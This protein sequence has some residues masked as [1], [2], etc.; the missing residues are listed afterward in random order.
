MADREPEIVVGALDA[1]QLPKQPKPVVREPEAPSPAP[2]KAVAAALVVENPQTLQPEQKRAEDAQTSAEPLD[3]AQRADTVAVAPAAPVTP[4]TAPA[5]RDAENQRPVVEP[6][7]VSTPKPDEPIPVAA[8]AVEPKKPEILVSTQ[9]SLEVTT[10]QPAPDAPTPSQPGPVIAPPVAVDAAPPPDDGTL[11]RGD[12]G[13]DVEML[14]YR[15]Q[16]VGFGGPD[17]APLQRTGHFDAPTEHAVRAFQRERGLPD[18]GHYDPDTV[19]ALA[20][21]Q[22]AK[23]ES[24]KAEKSTVETHAVEKAA[25]PT[26]MAATLNGERTVEPVA[27][28]L[29]SSPPDA[30]PVEA[31]RQA[32]PSPL[33][34]KEHSTDREQ[35]HAQF[36]DMAAPAQSMDAQDL[37]CMSPADQATFAKIRAGAP[38]HVSDETVA[39]AMLSAKRDKI[40]DADSIAQVCV[41]NG[42]LWVGSTTPGFYGAASLCEQPPAMQDTLRET[43]SYNQQLALEAAQR[44]PD[45]PSRGGPKM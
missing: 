36:G 14:Q 44:G 42:K 3:A 10:P 32:G 9:P 21:A 16:R 11:R 13:D 20:I 6:T 7:Q 12:R 29:A 28:S 31:S 38:G 17:D 5:V 19:Q 18:T 15:L 4:P 40:H 25:K 43:Q 45:D 39:A 2:V 24:Q 1:D 23:I 27:A 35:H 34:G 37:A 8:P 30:H 26:E 33:T 41:A 22:Q